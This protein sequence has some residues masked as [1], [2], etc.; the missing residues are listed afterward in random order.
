MPKKVKPEELFKR[1]RA[2]VSF[3]DDYLGE[4]DKQLVALQNQLYAMIIADYVPKLVTKDGFIILNEKNARVLAELDRV[5]DTFKKKFAEDVF[6]GTAEAMLKLTGLT[7]SYY[8]AFNLNAKTIANIEDKL[9]KMRLT[10]GI[11]T[12]GKVIQGSFIDK[13][14]STPQTKDLL[15]DYVRKGI[16]GQT[17]YKDFVDGFKQLIKGNK[18][19][20]GSME[21]YAKGYIHDSMYTHGQAVDNFFA[22]E[23][24]L[25]RFYYAGHLLKSSRP[26][27]AGGVDSKCGCTFEKKAGK[28]FTR[29]EGESWNELDWQG[30]IPAVDFFS[31]R[32]GYRCNHQLMWVHDEIEEEQMMNADNFE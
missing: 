1:Y 7:S 27:C 5:F 2:K 14:A 29:E 8:R 12:K 25:N 31:Q 19:V 23:L 22:D 20:D 4:Y 28:I 6:K 10:I 17:G 18:D 11:D 15:S 30:K 21:R 16:E 3:I 9:S 32:G 26:F 24:G 13:L